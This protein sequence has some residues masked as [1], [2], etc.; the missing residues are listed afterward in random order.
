MGAK[1]F[2][3][4]KNG[5]EVARVLKPGKDEDE[6]GKILLATEEV[7]PGPFGWFDEGGDGLR[8]F[9]GEY[10]IEKFPGNEENLGL[11]QKCQGIEEV[12]G[13]LR[14]ED[15]IDSEISTQGFLKQV[16]TLN[17]CQKGCT[18]ARLPARV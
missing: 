14:Y 6:R 16:R 8:S 10:G 15:A 18:A 5:A 7:G 4:A 17:T 3:G 11:G 13:A 9:G 12:L 2:G 1:G